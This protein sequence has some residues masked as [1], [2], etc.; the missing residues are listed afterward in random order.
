MSLEDSILEFINRRFPINCNWDEDNC[1]YFA[2]ILCSRFMLT[3]YFNYTTNKFV[4][5]TESLKYYFDY[6]GKHNKEGN[7]LVDSN[8][9]LWQR[10]AEYAKLLDKFKD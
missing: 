1:Y 6:N 7:D 5:S 2:K 8:T 9:L 10:T 4:A 3:L